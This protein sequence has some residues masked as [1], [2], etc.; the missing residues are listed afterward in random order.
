MDEAVSK[1]A[2]EAADMCVAGS[3]G[4]AGLPLHAFV[5]SFFLVCGRFD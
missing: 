4:V 3:W 1:V 2:E 5:I